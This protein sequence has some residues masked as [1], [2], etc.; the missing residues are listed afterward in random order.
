MYLVVMAVQNISGIEY[1]PAFFDC[2]YFLAIFD[3]EISLP[4]AISF[5]QPLV[6]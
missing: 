1:L 3:L 6:L 5:A 4:S 2:A